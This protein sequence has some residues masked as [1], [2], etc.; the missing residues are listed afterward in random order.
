MHMT[1]RCGVGCRGNLGHSCRSLAAG[2]IKAGE[3]SDAVLIC[4]LQCV[5][6]TAVDRHLSELMLQYQ[7]EQELPHCR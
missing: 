2:G 4:R 3:R 7:S 6:V 5:P 1:C